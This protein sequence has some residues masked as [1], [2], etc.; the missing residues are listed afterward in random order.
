MQAPLTIVEILG[1]SQQGQTR[2]FQCRGDDGHLYYV[3]GHDAGRRSLICEWLGGHLARAFG[4]PVPDFRVALI[5]PQLLA[6]HAGRNDLGSAPVFASRMV[7]KAQEFSLA[8]RNKVPASLRRDV[9]MFDGW[10]HNADRTLT[11]HGGNPNLLWRIAPSGLAVIDHNLAFDEGFDEELFCQTHVF[12]AEIPALDQDLFEAQRFH[13]KFASA[14]E[15]W[16]QACETVPPEWWF[17]DEAQIVPSAFDPSAA[18][19]LLSRY[20]D[21]DFRRLF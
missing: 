21:A 3:K 20:A 5:P 18:L 10:I 6:I 16:D 1:R 12:A 13:R 2:P 8:H 19:A 4:L 14:L 7:E 15:V 17:A 11:T 9:L